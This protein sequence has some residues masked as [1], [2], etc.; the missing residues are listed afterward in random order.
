MDW[1]A[2]YSWNIQSAPKGL[3]KVRKMLFSEADSSLVTLLKT[4]RL[5][6][7]TNL[8]P[9]YLVIVISGA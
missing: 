1:A 3:K 5:G 7:N 6:I 9:Q 4:A 8:A 2:G